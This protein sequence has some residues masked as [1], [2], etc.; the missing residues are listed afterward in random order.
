[1]GVGAALAAS[2]YGAFCF[3]RRRMNEKKEEERKN[4]TRRQMR[5][6]PQEDDDVIKYERKNLQLFL[7]KRIF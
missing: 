2:F 5:R 1:M 7:F 3:I 6:I 4:K